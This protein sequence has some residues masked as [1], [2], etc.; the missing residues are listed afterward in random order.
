MDVAHR[1][2]RPTLPCRSTTTTHVDAMAKQPAQDV[3]GVALKSASSLMGLQLFSRLATFSLNQALVRLSTPQ[4]YGTVSIQL[5]LFLNTVLFLSREG[6]RN[7]LLRADSKTKEN[8][9]SPSVYNI[10]LLPVYTG[11]G[12]C[13]L[14][15]FLY[16]RFA[17]PATKSQPHFMSTVAVY[18]VASLIELLS[19]PLLIRSVFCVCIEVHY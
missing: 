15:V 11:L 3:S 7:A 19:E 14:V 12:V 5:E 13:G 6:F 4:V 16:T 17:S 9:I 8:R 2:F 1:P 18:A 10:A